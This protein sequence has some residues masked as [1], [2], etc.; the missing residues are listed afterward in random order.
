MTGPDHS[1]TPADIAVTIIIT[2]TEA[3]P[4]HITDTPTEAL[5]VTIT[6]ALIVITATH[7]TGDLHPVEAPPLT[8]EMVA[9]PE[10]V[11]IQ[12]K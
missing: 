6:Q 1:H 8:P 11:P 2:H 5:H 10:H 12:T 4:G 7:H 9:D 3:T